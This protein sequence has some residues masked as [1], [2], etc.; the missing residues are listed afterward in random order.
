MRN[1]N[2][3]GAGLQLVVAILSITE[4]IKG[5]VQSGKNDASHWLSL[6]NEAYSRKVGMPI[7]PGSLNLVMDQRFDWYAPRYK[8]GLIW[9]G[10]EEYGGAR[11]I[12]M[13]PCILAS[14]KN[15]KAFIWATINAARELQGP[16]VVEIV[17][18]VKLRDVYQLF[19]GDWVEIEVPIS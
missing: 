6:F 19:D 7:F 12:L 13:H 5:R 9:F 15:H 16:W 3:V 18:D 1:N 2:I 11:D 17:T 14:L 8:S 10:Q 4:K